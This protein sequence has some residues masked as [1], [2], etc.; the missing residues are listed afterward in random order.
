ME[1]SENVIELKKSS[2]RD[3]A[4]KAVFTVSAFFSVAAVAGIVFFILLESIPAFSEIGVFNFIFGTTWAPTKDFLPVSERF[5]ILPMIVG[6]VAVT[7]GA[8]LVGGTTGVFTAVFLACFCPKRLKAVFNQVINLLAG[9]PSIV[10][11]YFGL[12]ALVPL[13]A[14]SSPTGS[15]QGALASS[16]ILGLMILPTVASIVRNSLEAVPEGLLEGALALGCTKAQAVFK[17]ILPASKSGTVTGIIMGIGRAVGETMAVMMIAGN[18]PQ[19][20]EGPFTSIRT[21]TI[22]IVMEMN[23][24]EGLHMNALIATGFVL[25]VLVLLLNAIL[26]YV[27]RRKKPLSK[28]ASLN[29]KGQSGI[30][31]VFKKTGGV[32]ESLKYASAAIACIVALCLAFLIV[33]VFVK[34]VGHISWD[35]LFGESGNEK[36]TLRPAFVSTG[37]LILLSL[38]VALPVG[39]A[40]AVYLAEYSGRG[41]RAVRVVRLFVDTLASIPSI[42][43]GLFGS[44][45]FGELLGMGYSLLSGG[46]TLALIVLPTIIRSA[47]ESILAVSDSLR[48]AS[49]ALGAGKART[50]FKVVLPAAM[51]GIITAVIL[52]VGRIVGESAALIYTAGAVPYTPQSYLDEG[53][54]FAVMMWMFSGEGMYV[55]SAYATACI[56]MIFVAILNLLVTMCE[57]KFRK[58]SGAVK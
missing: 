19:F 7:A 48:E 28:N 56:L 14:K 53:S 31:H 39:V 3:K 4:A 58:K 40:T 8:I 34:G 46:L 25:L 24:A 35:L 37:M 1:Q 6:S 5:G 47:E 27:N 9:I 42:V 22:N 38:A 21:L 55:D 29:S 20:I 2:A 17:V 26:A 32:C 45:V 50:I 49:L 57:R 23:Y 41:S 12:V 13:L 44:L 11:G 52:S 36:M 54:T 51:S 16:I 15:G 33:F 10:Y 30:T 43:F 18:S